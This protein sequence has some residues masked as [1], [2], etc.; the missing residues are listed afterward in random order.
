MSALR[1]GLKTVCGRQGTAA[2]QAQFTHKL[3]LPLQTT[4]HTELC[5][6]VAW[7]RPKRHIL[8]AAE[9][10]ALAE[11]IIGSTSLLT[12]SQRQRSAYRRK[13]YGGCEA[14]SCRP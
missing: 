12:T 8:V 6:R 2:D 14:N 5:A 7:F 13:Q 1:R 11:S 4:V 3:I 9:G 10:R